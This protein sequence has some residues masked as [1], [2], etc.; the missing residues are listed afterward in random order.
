VT[1]NWTTLLSSKKNVSKVVGFAEGHMS[2]KDFYSHFTNTTGGGI[3]RDLLRD[4]G[5][6]NSR[7]LAR[8]ALSRR[9]IA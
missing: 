1:T 4:H 5:V 2:G 9:G 7:R 6:I 8:K 3:V